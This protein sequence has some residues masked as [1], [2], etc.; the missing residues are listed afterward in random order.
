MAIPILLHDELSVSDD[1]SFDRIGT[2]S[3][4]VF[5][6]F[7]SYSCEFDSRSRGQAD[8]RLLT[9]ICASLGLRME[10]KTL[11]VLSLCHALCIALVYIGRGEL[12]C[13]YSVTWVRVR[14]RV[15]VGVRARVPVRVRVRG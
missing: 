11:S 1:I 4:F 8:A 6:T 15:R 14:V 12:A 13:E 3:A 7:S 10:F 9:R 5:D 2:L